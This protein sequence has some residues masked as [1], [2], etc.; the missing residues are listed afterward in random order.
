[1]NDPCSYLVLSTLLPYTTYHSS[2]SELHV[3]F[4]RRSSACNPIRTRFPSST[5]IGRSIS[6]IRVARWPIASFTTAGTALWAG[7]AA[8]AP[9][10]P[11]ASEALPEPLAVRPPNIV[12]RDLS[13]RKCAVFSCGAV[14]L[15][16]GR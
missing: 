12:W 15:F 13:D 11:S 7:R 14:T 9:L 10:A 5:A 1:M 2:W 16:Q 4:P 8:L 6:H 3:R